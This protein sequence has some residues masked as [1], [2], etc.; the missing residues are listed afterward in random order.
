MQPGPPY[1]PPPYYPPATPYAAAPYGAGPVPGQPLPPQMAYAPPP[2]GLRVVRKS[3]VSGAI[4]LPLIGL[5]IVGI[6]CP[7]LPWVDAGPETFNLWELMGNIWDVGGDAMKTWSGQYFGYLWLVVAI[8]AFFL[9]MAGTTDNAG[10]RITYGV[11]YCLIGVA[12]F[13]STLLSLVLVGAAAGA[14]G[15]EFN[16]EGTGLAVGV[17]AAILLFAFVVFVG[18]AVLLF[19]MKGAGYRVLAGLGLLSFAAVHFSALASLPEGA[20]LEPGAY[21]SILGYLLCAVGCFIG[22]RYFSVWAA[23]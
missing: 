22:P 7:S 17:F 15:S 6:V 11:I 10:W 1:G 23:R 2:A 13:G 5:L 12:F 18:V 8:W 20:E 16:T 3:R 4:A 21:L 9:S 19:K 14:M